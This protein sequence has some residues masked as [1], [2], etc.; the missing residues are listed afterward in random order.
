MLMYRRRG[1]QSAVYEEL[2][3]GLLQMQKG[4][5]EL[6]VYESVGIR[7]GQVHYKKLMALFISDKRRGSIPLMEAMNQEMFS[8]MEEKRRKTRQ[9]GEKIG[10]KL[11]IPMIGMLG[12]VFL[13]ILVPAFL[14][15]GL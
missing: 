9:Q 4:I 6:E 8:A 3:W 1:V 11:L 7:T 10:T 5:S 13:I 15:F 12:V 2:N 14:S